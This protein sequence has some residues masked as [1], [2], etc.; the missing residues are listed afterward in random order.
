MP[1][2]NYFRAGFVSAAVIVILATAKYCLVVRGILRPGAQP[3]PFFL[4]GLFTF[5]GIAAQV[6]AGRLPWFSK[7]SADQ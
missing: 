2:L 5:F 7:R 3:V 6:R 1:R 4:F